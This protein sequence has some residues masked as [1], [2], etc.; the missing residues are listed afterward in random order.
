MLEQMYNKVYS[1]ATIGKDVQ[2]VTVEKF[3]YLL[4]KYLSLTNNDHNIFKKLNYELYNYPNP[5]NPNTNIV[6]TTPT[7]NNYTIKI[8]NILGQEIAILYNGYLSE[9][10]HKFEFNVENINTGIYLVNIISD[11]KN[12]VH[13]IILQK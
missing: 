12:M 8:Y 5:F 2:F 3:Y 1:D 7:A 4:N 11:N 10:M 6:F 13:K 9:G